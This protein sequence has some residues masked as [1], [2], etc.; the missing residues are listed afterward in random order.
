MIISKKM[1]SNIEINKLE[2]LVKLKTLIEDSN[3]KVNLSQIARELSCD[4]RTV[5]KYING[6]EKVSKR[7]RKSPIDDYY[8]I[9][10]ELLK[11]KT[12]TFYYK[13]V[14]WQYLVDNYGL[15]VKQSTF[16][17]YISRHP[18]FNKYFKNK[19]K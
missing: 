19:Q 17:G 4:R 3:L 8:S 11:S 5:K 2:D 7:K 18:E 15:K 6:Y 13:K 10:K 1:N 16:R 9:I 14:L 12:K